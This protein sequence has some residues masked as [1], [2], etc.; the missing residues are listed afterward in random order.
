MKPEVA[1]LFGEL[2]GVPPYE[3]ERY[4]AAHSISEDVRREVESLIAFDSG[5]PL[6]NIVHKAV[7]LA[8]QEP[9]LRRRLLRPVPASA[10]DRT[11]R[12][13]SRLSRRARRWR[14]PP[15]GRGQTAARVARFP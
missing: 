5:A 12:D 6:E 13:G 7:G 8:F 2:S 11:R 3:R 14:S 10:L 1:T 15:A 9:R 4:Y